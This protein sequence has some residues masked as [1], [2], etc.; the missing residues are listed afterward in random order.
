MCG[1]VCAGTSSSSSLQKVEQLAEEKEREK[2]S[3]QKV[4]QLAEEKEREKYSKM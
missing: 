3:L 4:E 2:C 1:S